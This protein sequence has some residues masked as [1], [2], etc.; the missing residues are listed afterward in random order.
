MCVASSYH[1]PLAASS[2]GFSQMRTSQLNAKAIITIPGFPTLLLA[3]SAMSHAWVLGMKQR[4][5][6][7]AHRGEARC[8]GAEDEENDRQLVYMSFCS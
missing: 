6:L 8:G 2:H 1:S 3:K 7:C 4:Q 5:C